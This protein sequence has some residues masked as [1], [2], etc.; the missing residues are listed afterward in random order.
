MPHYA[1]KIPAIL[2]A[3]AFLAV[4]AWSRNGREPRARHAGDQTP[5]QQPGAAFKFVSPLP[6]GDWEQ[7]AGDLANTRY[8]P[9]NQINTQNVKNLKPIAVY[10]TGITAGHEGQP[11]VVNDTMYVVTPYP[12][13]VIA[14]DLKNLTGPVK[15]EYNPHP[16]P[17]SQGRA[18][19]DVVN[20]GAAYGDGKIV[21]QALDNTV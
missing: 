16:D 17:T 10:S 14:Y 19:C 7:P 15:W 18:C 9:L 6:N 12:N 5:A 20:R 11:L 13:L 8:S 21:Y 3:V 1:R 4:G 2:I